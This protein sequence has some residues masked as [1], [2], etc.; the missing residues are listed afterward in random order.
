MRILLPFYSFDVFV[1]DCFPT[2]GFVDE[3]TQRSLKETIVKM[4]IVYF[5]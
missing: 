2:G 3:N 5:E 4:H 1:L